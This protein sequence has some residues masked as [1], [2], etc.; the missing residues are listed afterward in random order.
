MKAFVIKQHEKTA[1]IV[2]AIRDEELKNIAGGLQM[3][4]SCPGGKLNTVTSNSD[5]TG[6]DDGCD[7]E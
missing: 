2:R 6:G 5:G 1:P 3:V 7:P 4:D